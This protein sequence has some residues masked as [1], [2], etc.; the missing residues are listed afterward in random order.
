MKQTTKH[1]LSLALTCA[2]ALSAPAQGRADAAAPRSSYDAE[3]LLRTLLVASPYRIPDNAMRGTIRYRVEFDDATAW[4]WPETGE[5]HV[6]RNGDATTLTICADCGEETPPSKD[7]LQRALAPNDWVQSDDYRIRDFAR[8]ARGNSVDARMQSLAVLVR[9]HMGGDIDFSRYDSAKQAFDSRSG[10]CT[11]YAVLL[12]A[13][14]RSRGV[15]ARVVAGI[16][17]SSRF[18]GRKHAFSPHLWVQTWNGQRWVSHDAAL[19]RFDASHIA[20]A[21]GDGSPQDF[22]QVMHAIAH[23]RIVDAEAVVEDGDTANATR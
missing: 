10:D 18:L 11:E 1:G 16:A 23:L 2:A 12:A 21:I 20:I 8:A 3:Q 15:P 19:E 17:Y 5:Q 9:Q 22:A 14:A 6:E 7:A 13:T 4:H